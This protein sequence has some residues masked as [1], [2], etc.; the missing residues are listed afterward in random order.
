MNTI[1]LSLPDGSQVYI[2]TVAVAA[3]GEAVAAATPG[4]PKPIDIEE[5]VKKLRNALGV[6]G[7]AGQSVLSSLKQMEAKE[8]TLTMGLG[9]TAEGHI[10]IA[11][12][13][14]AANF[15][16]SFVWKTQAEAPA[17]SKN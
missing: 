3:T 5:A 16:V 15:E 1:S 10:L 4:T 12:V 11:K 2:D 13:G 14:A 17:S 7:Q 9:F 8:A 6:I